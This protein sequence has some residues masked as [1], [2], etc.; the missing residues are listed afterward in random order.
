MT[1]SLPIVPVLEGW[2]GMDAEVLPWEKGS[3][4]LLFSTPPLRPSRII[5]ALDKTWVLL[6]S[7]VSHM[8]PQTG[9]GGYGVYRALL[10]HLQ[11]LPTGSTTATSVC[12]RAL[13]FQD[14]ARSSSTAGSI[15]TLL[16][17]H[18][19]LTCASAASR[20]TKTAAQ[21]KVQ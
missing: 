10:L 3:H 14:G 20:G 7:I 9:P 19:P 6:F 2:R 13:W 18:K 15:I 8:H 16:P 11:Q 5:A 21:A 1:F 17:V 12:T 4:D